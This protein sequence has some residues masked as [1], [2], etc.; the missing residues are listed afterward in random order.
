MKTAQDRQFEF[1]PTGLRLASQAHGMF[2]IAVL[3]G[4]LS[5]MHPALGNDTAAAAEIH[6]RGECRTDGVLVLL[7]DVAEIYS[8]NP[9]EV[10]ALGRIDL[11]PAPADGQKRYLRLREIEDL[12]V[13]RGL[14]M[15][16]HR[17]S[18][19]AR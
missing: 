14:N 16:E 3:L 2:R 5:L 7:A 17:F 19:P 13:L 11:I 8:T 15:R 10:K 12:L 4:T 9:D 18:V 1:H 6:L